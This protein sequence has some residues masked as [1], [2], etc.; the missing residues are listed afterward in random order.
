MHINLFET[1]VA[2]WMGRDAQL[3]VYSEFCGK[4]VAVEHD[5]SVYSCDH[6]VYP[7]YKLG[8][9]GD[10]HESRMVFSQEQKKFGFAKRDDLPQQCRQCKYKVRLLG[11]MS[12]K[13]ADSDPRRRAG[14]EL[15]VQRTPEVLAAHRSRHERH[16]A[17]CPASWDTSGS[18]EL[19]CVEKPDERAKGSQNA[20]LESGWSKDSQWL[21]QFFE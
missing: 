21:N 6:Y 17:S 14:L 16:F 10:K 2:Q 3:C 19:S 20:G 7:E 4:G 18:P 15:P 13:P 1:A 12:Q 9:I 11:R 5:G 8:N